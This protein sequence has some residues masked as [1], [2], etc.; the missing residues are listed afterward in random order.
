MASLG[1]TVSL[2]LAAIIVFAMLYFLLARMG[3]ADFTGLSATSTPLDALYFSTT[4]QSSVGFGDVHP[5]SGRAKLL[6][7]LQQ[8]V[9]IAGVVDLMSSGGVT[10]AIKS[11][12]NKNKTPPATISTTISNVPTSS[13]V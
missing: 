8:F 11:N 7:M 3:G 1:R 2:N 13:A 10:S 9:L 6:V 5:T 12:F 4:V